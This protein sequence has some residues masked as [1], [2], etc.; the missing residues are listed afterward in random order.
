MGGGL[1][2]LYFPNFLENS[3]YLAK[4]KERDMKLCWCGLNFV[5]PTMNVMLN[6]RVA[7][8]F[9]CSV[10]K[11][12]KGS[13]HHKQQQQHQQQLERYFIDTNF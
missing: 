10:K 13:K 11:K 3:Q 8:C 7:A 6:Q 1:G 2:K 9:I 4:E 12:K 5:L